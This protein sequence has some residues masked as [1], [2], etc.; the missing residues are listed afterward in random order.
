[1]RTSKP[2]SDWTFS[3]SS[4]ARGRLDARLLVAERADAAVDDRGRGRLAEVVTHRG[5]HDGRQPRA[6]E[7]GISRS[8]PRRSPSA[9]E[10]RRRPR[11]AIPV[12]AGQPMSACISGS[13]RAVTPISRA[14]AKPIDGRA[15]WSS[16]FSNSPQTRSAGR[17]S[18]GMAR[19]MVLRFLIRRELEARGELQ[20]AQAPAGNRPQRSSGRRR[21]AARR[22]RSARPPNGSSY[23]PVSGSQEIALTVKSRRR[24]ASSKR[25]GRIAGD[26]EALVSAPGLRLAPWQRH[27]DAPIL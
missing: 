21:A 7:I 5:E 4:S 12:P 25:H 14:S 20:R 1:M 11:D 16:S 9:C 17:S 15:A 13:S 10:S 6:I 24:A 23:S 19:Q 3:R 26:G 2:S 8:V 22:S 27:V 18:S